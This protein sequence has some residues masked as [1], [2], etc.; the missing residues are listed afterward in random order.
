MLY[1]E[2]K[3]ASLWEAWASS[4]LAPMEVPERSSWFASVRE[5]PGFLSNVR[6]N[7]MTRTENSKDLLGK[8][9]LILK[10]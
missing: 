4:I 8:S 6:H 3:P 2:M 7:L 5:T 9:D 1:F 10:V